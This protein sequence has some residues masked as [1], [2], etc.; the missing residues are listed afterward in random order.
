[1]K[2]SYDIT[3]VESN[4]AFRE[5]LVEKFVQQNLPPKAHKENKISGISAID[6]RYTVFES[7]AAE[8]P[9][10]GTVEIFFTGTFFNANRR[11][12]IPARS[13]FF[14]FCTRDEMNHYKVAFS[15]SLS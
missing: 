10:V 11:I 1:M 13:R 7:C 4:A 6:D 15:C 12:S 14:V 5:K 8:T 2:N 9:V 3:S